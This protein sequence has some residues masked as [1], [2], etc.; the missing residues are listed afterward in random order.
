MTHNPEY[1]RV[2][3]KIR[4]QISIQITQGKVQLASSKH[5]LNT[6]RRIALLL[7]KKIHVDKS[8]VQRATN[9]RRHN[10][11]KR[12]HITLISLGHHS[13]TNR[14]MQNNETPNE[15]QANKEAAPE[16]ALKHDLCYSLEQPVSSD[17]SLHSEKPSQRY[18]LSMQVPSLHCHWAAPHTVQQLTVRQGREGVQGSKS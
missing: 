2:S 18:F 4:S 10:I 12:H 13:L 3:L 11:G 16:A 9:L 5:I 8:R 6:E 14:Y 7:R 1:W 15:N 17:P